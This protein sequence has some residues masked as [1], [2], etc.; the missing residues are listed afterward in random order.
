MGDGVS[1]S[2]LARI[3]RRDAPLA[4]APLL[5]A[6]SALPRR[7]HLKSA[8]LQPLA[9]DAPTIHLLARSVW[10]RLAETAGVPT[11]VCTPAQHERRDASGSR[12]DEDRQ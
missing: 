10:G 12:I 4:A 2:R 3:R 5:L 1:V 9:L 6:N 11:F 8:E 7:V